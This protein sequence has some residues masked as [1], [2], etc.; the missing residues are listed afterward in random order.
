MSSH[1]LEDTQESPLV[2][3]G[4]IHLIRGDQTARAVLGSCIGLAIFDTYKKFA[5]LAHIVLPE[6]GGREGP[7]GKFA[8][9]A[10][11][12]MVQMLEENKASRSSLFA[13][14][15]GGAEM[16]GKLGPLQ[17]G[18]ENIQAVTRVL[19]KWNIPIIGAHVGG[20][21]GRRISCRTNGELT[22]EILRQQSVTI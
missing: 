20:T 19:N 8:D 2:L 17:I 7:P 1:V 4:Q 6:S 9:T 16:F 5:A 18:N 22:I 21:Q 11:L 10:I 15:A 12:H 14:F 13:K 3:I